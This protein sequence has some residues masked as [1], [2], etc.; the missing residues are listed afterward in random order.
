MRESKQLEQC[1]PTADH[2]L[3]NQYRQ[4]DTNILALEFDGGATVTY[5]FVAHQKVLLIFTSTTM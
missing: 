1:M 5:N 4:V 2:A 3:H